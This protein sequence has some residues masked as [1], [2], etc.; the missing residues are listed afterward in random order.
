VR[1]AAN[2]HLTQLLLAWRE[3]DETAL[4]EL[5]PIAYH[6]LHRL[7][8]RYMKAERPGH[9]LQA[10]ALNISVRTVLR[11][12]SLAQAWLLTELKRGGSR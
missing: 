7:A 12:W 5:T 8:Q 4:D 10:A 11:E 3:G 9:L 1:S 2:P 6:E